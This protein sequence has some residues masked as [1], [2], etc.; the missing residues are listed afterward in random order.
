M[1]RWREPVYDRTATDVANRVAKAFF[2]VT[3]WLRVYENTIQ[4]QGVLNALMAQEVVLTDLAN[5]TMYQ[6]VDVDEI[7]SLVA[8]ID[9]LREYTAVNISTG[10]IPLP[11]DYLAGPGAT[12]PSYLTVNDWEQDLLLIREILVRYADYR[13][14]CGVAAC[15]QLRFWQSRFQNWMEYIQDD[16]TPAQSARTGI[17]VSGARLLDNNFFRRYSI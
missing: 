12:A 7:N 13:I 8:N 17:A 14:S 15:G 1:T 9:L 4:D 16:P 11:H 5:P 2:N 10:L 3:D 6:L